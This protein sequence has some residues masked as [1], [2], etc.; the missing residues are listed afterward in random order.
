MPV[1]TAAGRALVPG[2]VHV[3]R[4][5]VVQSLRAVVRFDDLDCGPVLDQNTSQ[6]L[7]SLG[8][9]LGVGGPK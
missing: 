3:G 8:E 6:A 4:V 7:A 1:V 9:L 5:D 2:V